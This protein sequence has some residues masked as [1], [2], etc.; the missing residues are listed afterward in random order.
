MGLMAMGTR[1]SG[2]YGGGMTI[3]AFDHDKL[4]AYRLAREGAREVRRILLIVPRG[5]AEAVDQLKR[6]SLSVCLNT[7]EGA[8]TWLPKEK[9]RFYRIARASATEC[10]AVLDNLV[11]SEVLTE[12]DVIN[13]RALYSRV[14]ATLVKL[15]LSMD[16]TARDPVPAPRPVRANQPRNR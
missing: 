10:A 7:A 16:V 6:A 4:D 1:G 2:R 13:A 11:D 8:G 12:K 9:A 15:A 3:S 5:N 14:A